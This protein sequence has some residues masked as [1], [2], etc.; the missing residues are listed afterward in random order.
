MGFLK[1]IPFKDFAVAIYIVVAIVMLIIPMPA[2]LLDVLLA[3]DF[4]VSMTIMFGTM[5]A[6]EVLSMSFFPTMLLFTTVFRIGR[7]PDGTFRFFIAEGK[8]LDRPKQF[9]GTSTVIEMEF[10]AEMIIHE[11]VLDGWE[12]HYAVIYADVADELEMLAHMF[13]AEVRRY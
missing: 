13:R 12:P 2:P 9:F 1:K 7:N 10:S 3:C 4:A 11:A 6:P 5:F 8:A